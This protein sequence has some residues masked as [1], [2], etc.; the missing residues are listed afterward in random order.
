MCLSCV[1]HTAMLHGRVS[2]GVPFRIKAIFPIVLTRPR[3]TV[4]PRPWHSG[5]S[6]VVWYK[7]VCMPCYQT[8]CDMG[9]S[10]GYVR[11]RTYSHGRVTLK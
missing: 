6:S 10:G 3:H 7:S 11:H 4:F 8:A 9:V 1:Q 2:P 5:V